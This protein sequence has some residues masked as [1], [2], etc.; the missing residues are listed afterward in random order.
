MFPATLLKVPEGIVKQI[1][2]LLYRFVW[3]TLGQSQKSTYYTGCEEWRIEHG[4]YK[5]SF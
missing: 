2:S 4:G 1:E 3:E 5:K